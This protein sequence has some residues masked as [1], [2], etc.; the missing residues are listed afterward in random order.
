MFWFFR[1]KGMWAVLGEEILRGLMNRHLEKISF[2]S[3]GCASGEEVYSLKILW[4]TLLLTDRPSPVLSITATDVNPVCLKR[5]KDG[6]Y[7][8]SS[9]KEVPE[10][11]LSK[12]FQFQEKGKCYSINA[13]LK[14]GISWR[15]HNLLTDIPESG[16]HIIFLRNNLL[17]YYVDEVKQPVMKKLLTRLRPGGFLIIGSHEKLPFETF[18]LS[19]YR[20]FPYIFKKQV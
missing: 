9:L 6:V 17:T 11:L 15:M 1:D 16:F 7:P 5:A 14:N 4:D 2:W 10:R 20:A 3:A 8:L 19:Q 12:Y 13:S 18:G